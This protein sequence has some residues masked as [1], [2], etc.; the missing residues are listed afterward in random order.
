MSLA[1]PIRF[2]SEAWPRPGFAEPRSASI[3]GFGNTGPLSATKQ[4][5]KDCNDQG[6]QVHGVSVGF[7]CGTWNWF[8]S[9]RR[10]WDLPCSRLH[11]GITSIDNIAK[12][13]KELSEAISG[14]YQFW[15]DA[16]KGCLEAAR[17][18]A[19]RIWPDFW[20]SGHTLS[21]NRG[22]TCIRIGR[23]AIVWLVCHVGQ[24]VSSVAW[25]TRSQNTE[26]GECLY[27][28][29]F[30]WCVTWAGIRP[31]GRWNGC[32]PSGLHWP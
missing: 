14:F 32:G 5:R 29:Y 4:K 26:L 7:I 1:L 24:K 13:T 10:R 27:L 21:V 11:L 16:L 23:R 12:K 2:V 17:S 8:D 20:S 31:S 30:Y 28:V 22:T 18:D 15:E 9:W 6:K 19:V 25:T 3:A